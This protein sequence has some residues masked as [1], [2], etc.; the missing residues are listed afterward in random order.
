MRR[1]SLVDPGSS[2]TAGVCFPVTICALSDVHLTPDLPYPTD[3]TWPTLIKWIW[4][5]IPT[6]FLYK[7]VCIPFHKKKAPWMSCKGFALFGK[8]IKGRT[9]EVRP[10]LNTFLCKFFHIKL[11]FNWLT[12]VC[13]LL[14][15]VMIILRYLL[16]FVILIWD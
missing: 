6:P 4:T 11:L 8:D 9:A 13:L 5:F 16:T 10:T 15:L 1:C 3:H 2:G 12:F 7:R 14:T